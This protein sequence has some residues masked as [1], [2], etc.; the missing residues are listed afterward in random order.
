MCI[1]YNQHNLFIPG[2]AKQIVLLDF[3]R[4]V[5]KNIYGGMERDPEYG[6]RRSTI[7]FVML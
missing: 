6:R 5:P 1:L 2:T 7:S 3:S 4:L